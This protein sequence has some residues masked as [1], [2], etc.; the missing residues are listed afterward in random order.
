MSLAVVYQGTFLL[1]TNTFTPKV[2]PVCDHVFDSAYCPDC[3]AERGATVEQLTWSIPDPM[4]LASNLA[5][6]RVD[7]NSRDQVILY[8][9]D[10]VVET[11]VFNN[12]LMP[13]PPPSAA[14][15]ER[16]QAAIKD[17]GQ[18]TVVTGTYIYL[19]QS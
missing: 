13:A 6:Q 5:L 17:L 14:Y 7:G 19:E 18:G 8:H 10:Y 15:I 2:V 3:G 12:N 4:R 9:P 16:L 1:L 11:E